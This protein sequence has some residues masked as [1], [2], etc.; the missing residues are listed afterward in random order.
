MNP[1]EIIVGVDGSPQARHA[2]RWAATEARRR[3]VDLVVVHVYDW[4]IYGAP[5]PVGAPFVVDAREVADAL[6]TEAVAEAATVA[7][8]VSVRGDAVLGSASHTLVS[9]AR[10]GAMLVVGCRG[11]GGFASLLLGSV[12]QQVLIH[13]PGPVVVVRGRGESATGPIVVGVDGSDAGNHA[14]GMAFDLAATRG[15]G[16]LAVRVYPPANAPVWGG[17]ALPLTEDPAQRRTAERT[18]LL[19]DVA[20]WTDK[21]PDVPVESVVVTGQPAEVLTGLSATAQLL[22]VG[23]RGHGGFAGLLLGSVGQQLAHHADCPVLIA[24]DLTAATPA[25]S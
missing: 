18:V 11:R 4:R 24:R 15:A 13:A 14:L 21:F 2:L 25:S 16:I 20:R 8:G 5:G 10:G 17:D 12:S 3:E 9:A 7:P 23:T 1:P 22:V 6:V 19:S